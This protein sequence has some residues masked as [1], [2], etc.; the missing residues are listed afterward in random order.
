MKFATIHHEGEDCA[1]IVDPDAGL[2][3]PLAGRSMLELIRSG[4]RPTAAG[5][6]IALDRVVLRAPIPTPARN[7]FCV[8]KN[9]RDHVAEMRSGPADEIPT[10]SGSVLAFTTATSMR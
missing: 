7:I 2:V 6:G 9:Y 3:W 10:R 1:A 8:G 4:E 5:E